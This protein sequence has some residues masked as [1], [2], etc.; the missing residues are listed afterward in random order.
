MPVGTRIFLLGSPPG[1]A[2]DAQSIF[3]KRFPSLEFV[4]ARDGFFSD[5]DGTHVAEQV[6]ATG[7]QLVIVGMGQPRQELWAT[8]YGNA[9][10]A[11]TLCAG[12]ILDFTAGRF[13]RAPSW[14]QA[15][16]ME[17]AFRLALEPKRLAGRYLVGNA[18]FMLHVLVQRFRK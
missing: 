15:I 2:E 8:R 13:K 10:G 5:E 9:C 14:V 7:A 1:V 6:A 12:A 18:S 3:A 11:V 17:W 4:G 16:R